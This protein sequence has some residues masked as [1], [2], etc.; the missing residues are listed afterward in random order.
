M[1]LLAMA[2][3]LTGC[4]TMRNGE[5]AVTLEFRPGASSPAPGLT[6]M[7]V[8]GSQAPVYISEDVV[9][10]NTDVRSS[11]VVLGPTG[12][13]IEIIFTKAGAARFATATESNIMKPLGILV[14]DQIICAPIVHEKISG[15][16]AVIAGTF[17]EAEARRIAEGI[18]VHVRIA[19]P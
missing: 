1:L 10:S 17:S 4:G 5:A 13:Q 16:R 12:P 19:V 18:A 2:T 8:P 11:R 15:G 14:D 3:V 7:T 6:R 9:L